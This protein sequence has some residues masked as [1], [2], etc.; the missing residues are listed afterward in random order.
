MDTVGEGLTCSARKAS[1]VKV[2]TDLTAS[3]ASMWNIVGPILIVVML[4]GPIFL[5]IAAEGTRFQKYRWI[6]IVYYVILM[7]WSGGGTGYNRITGEYH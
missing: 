7:I 5:F 2:E 4:V 1:K 6:I 3:G